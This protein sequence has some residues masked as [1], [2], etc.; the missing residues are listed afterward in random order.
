[1]AF[2]CVFRVQFLLVQRTFFVLAL[3]SVSMYHSR[4]QSHLL[5][6]DSLTL[7]AAFLQCVA[8]TI[9]LRRLSWIGEQCS[10]WIKSFF[11]L[12]YLSAGSCTVLT[13]TFCFPSSKWPFICYQ[14]GSQ[15]I[16]KCVCPMRTP[17]ALPLAYMGIRSSA[18][19]ETFFAVPVCTGLPF[20]LF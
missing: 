11:H 5:W 16:P 19:L 6:F 15:S 4:L 12:P 9:I 3:V 7:R 10:H 2:A 18:D 1:M 14:L 8:P 20:L 13:K 17:A